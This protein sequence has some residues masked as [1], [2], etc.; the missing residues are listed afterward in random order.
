MIGTSVS[1]DLERDDGDILHGPFIIKSGVSETITV[2]VGLRVTP[3]R[4]SL[5][6]DTAIPGTESGSGAI[7]SPKAHFDADIIAKRSNFSGKIE[8]PSPTK[9]LKEFVEALDALAPA[10][11]FIEEPV[12]TDTGLTE[13]SGMMSEPPANIR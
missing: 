2:D 8:V 3:E 12:P 10:E 7:A 5:S 1:M 6:L 9:P 11:S 13:D 4:F